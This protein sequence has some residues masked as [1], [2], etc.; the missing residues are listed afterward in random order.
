M[1]HDEY[2]LQKQVC[3]YLN[4]SYPEVLYMSDS[5]A[6]CKLTMVQAVRNKAIQKDGFKCP[7]I[8]ILEPRGK[9][10]GLFIELKITTPFKKDGTIKKNEHLEGQLKTI[11]EL[12]AKGYS[13]F[14]AVGFDEAK[15]LIDRYLKN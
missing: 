8:I 6:S 4:W 1:K 14:F 12:E 9:Y 7:D 15:F 3:N 5:I 2:H 10:H 11:D 13:A